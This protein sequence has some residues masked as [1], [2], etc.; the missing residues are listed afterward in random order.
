MHPLL[1]S[2]YKG[3]QWP[4]VK[5]RRNMEGNNMKLE[6]YDKVSLNFPQRHKAE[7]RAYQHNRR[8]QLL[9]PSIYRPSKT[10]QGEA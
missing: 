10:Y 8:A 2:D 3:H 9:Q 4:H 7:T 5:E 1:E 6:A